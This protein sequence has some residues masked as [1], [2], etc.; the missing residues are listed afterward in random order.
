MCKPQFEETTEGI[1]DFIFFHQKKQI[2]SNPTWDPRIF[3]WKYEKIAQYI[4]NRFETTNDRLEYYTAAIFLW[5]FIELDKLAVPFHERKNKFLVKKG[6]IKK[7]LSSK[8]G[9]NE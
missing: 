6:S 9:Q 3:S 2:S 1:N 8:S 7:T 4:L 5:G